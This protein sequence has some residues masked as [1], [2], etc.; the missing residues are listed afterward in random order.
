VPSD[1]K[2]AKRLT[3]NDFLEAASSDAADQD[4]ELFNWLFAAAKRSVRAMA[5]LVGF[6]DVEELAAKAMEKFYKNFDFPGLAALTIDH[7][8]NR[9]FHY[10]NLIVA[11]TVIDYQRGRKEGRELQL[12]QPLLE[13]SED[14]LPQAKAAIRQMPKN[15]RELL[16]L[17]LVRDLTYQEIQQYYSGPRK[18]PPS[19]SA[20]RTRKHRIIEQLRQRLLP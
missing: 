18:R 11:Q 16:D 12:L 13:I 20:L 3:V 7:R 6:A 14:R 8:R 15:D 1:H 17:K 10:L 5:D 19:I 4:L 2:T 9:L